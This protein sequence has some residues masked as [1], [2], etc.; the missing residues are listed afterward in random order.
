MEIK[1]QAA[2]PDTSAAVSSTMSFSKVSLTP[3]ALSAGL[4]LADFVIFP[5]RWVVGEGTFRPPYFHRN[6]M[7]EFMGMVCGSYDGK[8]GGFQPGGTACSHLP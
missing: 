7:S 8:E 3:A 1:L 6:C 2:H 5:P 4:A